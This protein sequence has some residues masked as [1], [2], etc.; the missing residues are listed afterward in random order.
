MDYDIEKITNEINFDDNFIGYQNEGVVLTNK[1]IR[2]LKN[3]GIDYKV[4]TSMTYL[5]NML[6]EYDDEEIEEILRDIQDRN[7]YL[8]T[9]K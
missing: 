3:L 7:Y 1:E 2:I 9:N 4:A 6:E 5:M 8:N